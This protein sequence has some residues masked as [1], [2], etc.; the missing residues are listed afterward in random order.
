MKG[1][2]LVSNIIS[3]CL[4]F[5]ACFSFFLP[6]WYFSKTPLIDTSQEN[7]ITRYIDIFS[8]NNFKD[9]K[10]NYEQ[11]NE[12][13]NLFLAYVFIILVIMTII[14]SI[15]YSVTILL[16]MSKKSAKY[17]N[18]NKYIN[19]FIISTFSLTII[20]LTI[21]LIFSKIS[22][23]ESASV[24]KISIKL[25]TGAYLFFAIEMAASLLGYVA[26]NNK[27]LNPPKTE[28]I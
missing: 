9:V 19:A 7:T 13:L 26:N 14:S 3:I 12:Y 18:I 17:P 1:P 10:I 5:L 6:I 22:T 16:S 8:Y 2:K 27:Q 21:A 20:S 15:V 25:S 28:N 4:H 24:Y 23:P 11:I